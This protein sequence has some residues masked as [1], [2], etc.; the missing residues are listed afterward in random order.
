MT[1]RI[2]F[3]P[4]EKYFPTKQKSLLGHNPLK[5]KE[6]IKKS[7]LFFQF[8]LTIKNN[9]SAIK[10]TELQSL[11]EKFTSALVLNYHCNNISSKG[12]NCLTQNRKL[13]NMKEHIPSKMLVSDKY[14]LC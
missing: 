9:L 3:W 12:E 2:C 6:I 8:D 5:T 11:S 1:I 10:L 13:S 7:G 4:A 14:Q